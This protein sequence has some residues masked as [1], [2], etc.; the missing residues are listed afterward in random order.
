M[1]KSKLKITEV[2]LCEIE[3]LS[4]DIKENS[5]SI[6]GSTSS[7]SALADL[8]QNVATSSSYGCGEIITTFDPK[9]DE[10]RM[11]VIRV[12][13]QAEIAGTPHVHVQ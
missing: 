4:I 7:L 13:D 11:L 10:Q 8:L 12:E 3:N 5:V 1:A 9:M 2:E 6:V